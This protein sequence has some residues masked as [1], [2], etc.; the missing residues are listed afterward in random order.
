MN[1]EGLPEGAQRL[2]DATEQVS[3]ERGNDAPTAQAIAW[4][5]VKSRFTQQGD[6]FV[7]ASDAFQE[8]EYLTFEA[9][10]GEELVSRSDD[11]HLIHTYVLSD[12][13]PDGRGKAPSL[14]LLN[15][16]AA[17]LNAMQPEIDTD[18]ELLNVA[19]E[20][21]RGDIDMVSNTMKFKKGIARLIG[22]VVDA[23]KLV[24]RVMF[25]K[26]YEKQ[27][28]KIRGMSFEAACKRSETGVWQEGR[29]F[30]GTFAV[31]SNPVNPRALRVYS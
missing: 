28:D 8:T 26:R 30:G 18:H 22:A 17:D 27:A 11:G 31:N 15:K 4:E 24:V 16:W 14:E 5:M 3:L 25:D 13:H 1:L 7:A 10:A 12:T 2:F 29:I 21:H 6:V 9:V 23:G 20:T 19:M